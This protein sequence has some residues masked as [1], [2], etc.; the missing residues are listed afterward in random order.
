MA[1]VNISVEIDDQG[2]EKY[3]E[4]DLEALFDSDTMLKMHQLL[5]DKCDPYVPYLTGDLS[6][7]V[8]VSPQSVTYTQPYAQKQYY[9]L[10]FNHTLDVHPLA[11]ALWDKVMMQNQ[12]DEFLAGVKEILIRRAKELY[13]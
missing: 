3:L 12:G 10:E 11:T 5:A 8:I 13:G 9:G 4:Q 7:K 1:F 2:L 6:K